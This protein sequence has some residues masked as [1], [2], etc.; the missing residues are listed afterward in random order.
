MLFYI[1]MYAGV[2]VC[3]KRLPFSNINQILPDL[4]AD[5]KAGPG[6]K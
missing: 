4:A 6:I 1:I 5:I 3:K 2:T